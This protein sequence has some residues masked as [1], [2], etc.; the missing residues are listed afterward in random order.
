[1]LG[2][3][4]RVQT[5]LAPAQVLISLHHEPLDTFTECILSHMLG[6]KLPDTGGGRSC[7]GFFCS[8]PHLASG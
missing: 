2:I 5:V 3:P 4:L 6:R 8:T 7:G 1:M